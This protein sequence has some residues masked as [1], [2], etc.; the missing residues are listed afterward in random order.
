LLASRQALPIVGEK[1]AIDGRT[2]A[3]VCERGRCLA[4]TSD[5]DV[6]ARQLEGVTPL[7]GADEK[8]D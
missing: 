3:Y 6:L 1:Q 8:G 5:P 4:P 2:T 7:P